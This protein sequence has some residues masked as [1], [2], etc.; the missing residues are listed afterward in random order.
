MKLFMHRLGAS[1]IVVVAT[2]GASEAQMV[3]VGPCRAIS[4]NESRLACYD[5]LGKNATSVVAPLSQASPSEKARSPV[6][7]ASSKPVAPMA[8]DVSDTIASDVSVTSA[9][10][11]YST[12]RNGKIILVLENGETWR[13]VDSRR[14]RI[15]KNQPLDVTIEAGAFGS[16]WLKVE[17]GGGAFRAEKIE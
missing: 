9:L 6:E 1:M 17:R 16:H 14:V 15:V 5:Q 8:S 11:R 2:T 10:V 3:D 13:Q 4:G 7:P 12:Q